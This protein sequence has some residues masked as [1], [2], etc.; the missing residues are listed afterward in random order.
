M[1]WFDIPQPYNRCLVQVLSKRND[2]AGQSNTFPHTAV[3][4][5]RE[6]KPEMKRW[7]WCL[8]IPMQKG[9]SKVFIKNKTLGKT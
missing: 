9:I 5:Q 7:M 4:I 3:T 6:T 8:N 1:V 2:E